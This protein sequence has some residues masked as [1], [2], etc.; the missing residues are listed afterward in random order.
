MPARENPPRGIAD[1]IVRAAHP[2]CP[3]TEYP[4]AGPRWRR[5]ASAAWTAR[6]RGWLGPR[7]ADGADHG[8]R[9]RRAPGRN[10][11]LRYAAACACVRAVRPTAAFRRTASAGLAVLATR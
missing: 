5:R 6:C 1:R 2:R 3:E 7:A 4:S 8:L 11:K 10:A 9:R